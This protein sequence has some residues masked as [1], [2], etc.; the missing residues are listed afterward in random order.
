MLLSIKALLLGIICQL[1]GS[2]L[3]LC[4]V[5]S[6][7]G[8]F[9]A[10]TPVAFPLALRL[11]GL[12][13]TKAQVLPCMVAPA[14]QGAAAIIHRSYWLHQDVAAEGDGLSC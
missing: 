11:K 10:G 1:M 2:S 13:P 14:I 6:A 3:G 12:A 4:L 8:S 5:V 7:P 9:E